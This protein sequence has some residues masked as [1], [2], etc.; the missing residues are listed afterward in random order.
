MAMTARIGLYTA[1]AGSADYPE[2]K[3][4]PTFRMKVIWNSQK[5]CTDGCL[6]GLLLSQTDSQIFVNIT[7]LI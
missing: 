2:V 6:L 3:I 1:A 5:I 4:G 7:M